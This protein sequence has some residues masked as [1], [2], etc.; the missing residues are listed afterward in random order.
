MNRKASRY[1]PWVVAGSV[2]AAVV[3]LLSVHPGRFSEP[4]GDSTAEDVIDEA[5][6]LGALVPQEGLLG[7]EDSLLPPC[8]VGASPS[9]ASPSPSLWRPSSCLPRHFSVLIVP[10]RDRED[11]FRRFLDFMH[12]FLRRQGLQ[13]LI[14]A[15]EQSR[16]GRP[17]NRAKLFNA[18]FLEARRA[19]GGASFCAVFHDVDLLPQSPRNVY[20]CTR[21]PRHLTASL[22]LFRYSLPYRDLFGG[23]VAMLAGDVEAVGG[24]SNLFFGERKKS[25]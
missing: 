15:V 13:Y 14:L 18:G 2:S 22:D 8:P 3:F 25:R 11:H 7:A 19:L 16:D 1:P 20:A 5:G 21:R 17:F 24:F 6:I 12:P 9:Y 23:G 10:L 4:Y